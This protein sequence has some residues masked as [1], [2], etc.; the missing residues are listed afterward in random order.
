MAW[1]GDTTDLQDVKLD[2]GTLTLGEAAAAERASGLTIDKL[3][4]GVHL[5]M[6]ALFVHLSRTYGEPPSW[7]EI[8][9]LRLLDV[10]P[11]RS[12]SPQDSRSARS[13]D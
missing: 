12:R 3:S 8:A 10:S 6:L 5:R 2:I 1:D 11:S 7:S 4:S 13:S 9:N